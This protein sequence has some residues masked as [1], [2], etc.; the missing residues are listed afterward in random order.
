MGFDRI[1]G[2][3]I[4]LFAQSLGLLD[5][6]VGFNIINLYSCYGTL[7]V[8]LVGGELGVMAVAGVF[9]WAVGRCDG[10]VKGEAGV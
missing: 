4:V 5:L 8:L 1:V 9:L 7:K 6:R 10:G 2:G 3:D